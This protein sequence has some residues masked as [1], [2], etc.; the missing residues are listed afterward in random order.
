MKLKRY[1]VTML[2]GGQHPV[3][4]DYG[5]LVGVGSEFRSSHLVIVVMSQFHFSTNLSEHSSEPVSRL[6]Y[7]LMLVLPHYVESEGCWVEGQQSYHTITKECF[8]APSVIDTNLIRCSY[9]SLGILKIITRSQMAPEPSSSN[10][11]NIP[12][13]VFKWLNLKSNHIRG[14]SC[15]PLSEST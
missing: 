12:S 13:K 11:K 2:G 7:L 5:S 9:A 8:Y 15:R 14:P 10:L 1:L 4:L 6:C 3:G